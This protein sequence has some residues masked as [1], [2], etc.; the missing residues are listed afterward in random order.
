LA[1][2]L[3]RYA[4]VAAALGAFAVA[5]L[6]LG[7][8]GAAQAGTFVCCDESSD[9]TPAGDLDAT[10]DF[11]V[12]GTTLTLTVTNDTAGGGDY[13]IT[14]VYFNAT[15]N[16]SSLTLTAAT[17]S[18]LGDVFVHWDPVMMDDMK[19]G[20][21]DFSYSIMDGEGETDPWLVT[22]GDSI[23]FE[24]TIGGT[25]PFDMSNFGVL[26]SSGY[27]M[28]AKFVNGPGDDSAF[29]ANIPEP[30]TA[31]LLGLGLVGIA[32]MRRRGAA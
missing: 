27:T 2:L 26:N 3:G 6:V 4:A 15:A 11:A 24:L 13:N 12:A 22:P 25:G 9:S 32:A 18:V 16:V 7:A 30:S 14:D 23:F 8:S 17:H 31:S 19:D 5:A 10:F 21:G 20:F 1:G 29:G 28:G